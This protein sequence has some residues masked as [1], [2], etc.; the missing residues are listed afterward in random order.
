MIVNFAKINVNF[1]IFRQFEI[2]MFFFIE[3][4]CFS[5]KVANCNANYMKTSVCANPGSD[6]PKRL[7]LRAGTVRDV[8]QETCVEPNGNND[9]KF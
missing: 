4:E 7:R 2:S 6:L 9:V 1:T 8:T 5:V 3:Y